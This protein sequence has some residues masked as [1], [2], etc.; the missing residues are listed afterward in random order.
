MPGK[1]SSSE[2]GAAG[3]NIPCIIDTAVD[4]ED[5][6]TDCFAGTQ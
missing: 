3:E 2:T 4:E 1:N 5:D 6:D